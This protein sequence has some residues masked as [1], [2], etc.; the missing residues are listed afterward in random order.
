MSYE[1]ISAM[2]SLVNIGTFL[3]AV[4]LLVPKS[5]KSWRLW[6]KTGK[7]AH[8]SGAVAGAVVAFFLLAGN[9]VTFMK[10]VLGF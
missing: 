5:V 9:F 10:A 8:L 3:L 7:D 6:K 2:S 1:T 4:M